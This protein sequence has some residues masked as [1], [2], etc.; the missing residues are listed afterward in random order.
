MKKLIFVS[1]LFL[2]GGGWFAYTYWKGTPEYSLMQIK[3]AVESHDVALFERHVDVDSLIQRAVDSVMAQSLSGIETNGS[4]IEALGGAI[5]A[6][7]IAMVKP[8]IVDY[9]KT[10]LIMAV[11]G[12]QPL[13]DES[14]QSGVAAAAASKFESVFGNSF[15]LDN[16]EILKD[17]HIAYLY[18]TR[19]DEELGEDLTLKFKMREMKGYW[20][21]IEASNLKELMSTTEKLRKTRLSEVNAL[22]E[23]RMKNILAITDIKLRSSK[24]TYSRAVTI[25]AKLQNSSNEDIRESLI[26]LEIK[27]NEGSIVKSARV[28]L[29]T[30]LLAGKLQ[31]RTWIFDVNQ[32]IPEDMAFYSLDGGSP[33]FSA[34]VSRIEFVNG[35]VLE[36]A[37]SL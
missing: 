30:E 3:R 34:K 36:M 21:V 26:I 20:Q 9:T 1:I 22:V 16:Y 35:E 18:V 15:D 12:G 29:T 4:G 17:G 27:D 25:T 28:S 31:Q 23:A 11:E 32:F 8:K 2:L 33:T 14:D 13:S 7:M 19:F 5:A 37:T 10:K 6:G 24:E